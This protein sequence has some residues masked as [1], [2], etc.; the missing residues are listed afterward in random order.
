MREQR[1]DALFRVDDI[2][3]GLLVDQQQNAVA[4][5]LPGR[6][7]RI[8]RTVDRDPDVPN[9]HCRAVLVRDDHIVPG[10]GLQQLVVVVD[11]HAAR[12]A[13]DRAFGRVHGGGGDDVCHI[14]HLQAQCRQFGRVDLHAY[15]RLLLAADRDLGDARYL[16]NLL[17]QNILGIVID[18]RDRQHVGMHRQDQNCRI[19]G[20]DLAIGG[21]RGQILRQLASGGVDAR[22]YVLR[23]GIDVAIQIE[24]QRDLTGAEHIG[25]GHLRQARDFRELV[26]QRRGD[27]GGHGF[28]AGARQLRR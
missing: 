10:C 7:Q 6:Q 4:A 14:L 2:G 13:V 1:F 27:R 12:R 9:A 8:L 20:I 28:G 22:L 5:V 23:S 11:R 21:R 19:G 3:A 15:R 25:R 17:R 24:L 18:G 26:F 16:R